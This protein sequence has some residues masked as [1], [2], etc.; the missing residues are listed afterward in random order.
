M[1][2]PRFVVGTVVLTMSALSAAVLVLLSVLF[3]ED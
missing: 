3:L 1:K 2:V